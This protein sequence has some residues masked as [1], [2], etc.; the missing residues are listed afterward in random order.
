MVLH[1]TFL[2]LK[3]LYRWEVFQKTFWVKDARNTL[4]AEKIL[5]H[6]IVKVTVHVT[7]HDT[8]T[9]NW[10]SQVSSLKKDCLQEKMDAKK[11]LHVSDCL[12]SGHKVIVKTGEADII[13]F[14]PAHYTR[15][16][17]LCGIMG[18]LGFGNY[19]CLFDINTFASNIPDLTLRGRR[20]FY[21]FTGVMPHHL[22]FV[23]NRML[24]SLQ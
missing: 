16:P 8:V 15:F 10:G 6:N 13:T 14:P 23:K 20:L 7:L 22:Q 12:N 4:V 5:S 17:C 2:S 11:N 19:S 1:S 21:V 9:D 3:R 24:E 18:N